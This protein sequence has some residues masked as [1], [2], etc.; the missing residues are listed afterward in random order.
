VDGQ[1]L[2][3]AGS[4]VDLDFGALTQ[5]VGEP[6]ATTQ[7]ACRPV[8]K[9]GHY[10]VKPR[11]AGNVGLRPKSNAGCWLRDWLYEVGM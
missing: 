10:A 11:D 3:I 2:K 8:E 4:G 1:T 5:Q 7:Y 6:D 9:T